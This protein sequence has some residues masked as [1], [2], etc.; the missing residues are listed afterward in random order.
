MAVNYT[1]EEWEVFL[2]DRLRNLRLN[3][4]I[5]QRTLAARAGISVRA[6]QNLESGSGS[7]LK[8]FLSV[9]RSLG[10]TEWLVS[11]AS[12]PTIN[13]VTMPKSNRQRQ[14]AGGPRRV[15]SA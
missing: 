14:R 11:M 2:G 6:L 10:Q 9:V 15:A 8:T 5:D 4:N 3:R 12:V 1:L 7:A 13:P